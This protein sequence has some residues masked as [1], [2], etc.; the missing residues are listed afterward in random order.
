MPDPIW[1]DFALIRIVPRV[2]RAEFL[3][4][5]VLVHAPTA[6]F[7]ALRLAPRWEA[8]RALDPDCDP[9]LIRRHLEGW[10]AVAEGRPEGGPLAR[11][12]PSER[13]HWLSAPRSTPI[14]CSPVH[15]GWTE[16]L[17]ATVEE[18]LAELVA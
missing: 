6:A 16:D 11:L 3:N 13:F 14:Q 18:L 7:L 4:V 5:G 12:S 9:A 1:Y 17:A 15:G 10:Q 2:E 8:L